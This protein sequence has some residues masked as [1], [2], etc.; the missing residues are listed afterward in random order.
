MKERKNFHWL[1]WLRFGLAIYI[2]LFHTLKEFY[3]FVRDDVFLYSLLNLGNLA[4]T[5]FFVLSGFLLTYVYISSANNSNLDRKKFWI[6]RFSSLYPLHFLTMLFSIP[7]FL[8]MLYIHNGV[9]VPIQPL[10][11]GVRALATWEIWLALIMNVTLT[12]AWNPLYLLLNGPS[13]SLSALF[14]FYAVFPFAASWLNKAR[15]PGIA[16]VLLGLLFL[17]PG[18][19]AQFLLQSSMITDGLL[20]RNPLIRLPLFLAGIALAVIYARLSDSAGRVDSPMSRPIAI[21]IVIVT[22]IGAAFFQYAYPETKLYILR[23][24]LYYPAAIAIV[25]LCATQRASATEWNRKWSSRMGKTSLPV[26]LLHSP[27]YDIFERVERFSR[28]FGMS[29]TEDFNLHALVLVARSLDH[30]LVLFPLYL[31]LVIYLADLCQVRFVEPLQS[32]LRGKLYRPDRLG[33]RKEILAV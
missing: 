30:K 26:F 5:I 7:A 4:T 11:G 33:G 3:P 32:Y 19:I 27:L 17:A 24:G 21:S 2:V 6:A 12:Q 16:L 23:N 14:F 15:R 31:F 22:L 9:S 28:A 29:E 1:N 18:F 10:G 25:W 13:W 20:H 8:F